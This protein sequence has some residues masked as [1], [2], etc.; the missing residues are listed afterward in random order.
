MNRTEQLIQAGRNL[1]AQQIKA[2]EDIAAS[3]KNNDVKQASQEMAAIILA[4][5]QDDSRCYKR[6]FRAGH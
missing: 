6:A 4:W 5:A 3:S 1:Y 2:Y